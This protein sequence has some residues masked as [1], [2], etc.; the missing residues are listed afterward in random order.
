MM[1]RKRRCLIVALGLFA[2]SG[3]VLAQ[4]DPVLEKARAQGQVGEQADGYLGIRG[5]IGGE[6]KAHVDQLNIKRK[7]VY[8]QTAVKRGVAVADVGAATACEL[9]AN[10]IASG[11]YYRDANGAWHQRVGN[12][13][14]PLPPY[15]G[16]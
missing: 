9:F 1:L 6:L 7:A 2:L 14:V 8:T 16:R 3:P 5:S 11:E 12:A 13:P 10:R 15:C 4:A